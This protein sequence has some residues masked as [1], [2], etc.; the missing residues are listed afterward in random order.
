M[1][2]GNWVPISKAFVDSLP[3]GRPYTE[4][5]AMFC[6]QCDYDQGQAVTVTGYTKLWRWGKGRVIRFLERMGV[7]IEYPE[8]TKIKQ[9]Q[10]GL[11]VILKPDRNRTGNGLKRAIDSKWLLPSADRK[12]TESG[13]K[14][15]RSRYTTRDPNPNPKENSPDFLILRARYPNQE[16]IDQAF[17]AIALTRKTGKVSDSILLAQLKKW[18]RFPV[19]LVEAAIRTYLDKRYYE[20]GKREAYLF[21]IIRGLNNDNPPT[22]YDQPSPQPTLGELLNND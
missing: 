17:A 6:I 7:A 3:K 4:L 5:E 20:Q 22:P 18:E 9:K 21:G 10:S 2:A 19:E 1:Q 13:L 16:L 11:I 15:D 8:S 14:A 12:R